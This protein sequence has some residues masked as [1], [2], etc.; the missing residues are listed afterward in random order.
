MLLLTN[1]TSSQKYLPFANMFADKC[2]YLLG[3]IE[4]SIKLSHKTYH[5]NL[6]SRPL[7]A[8]LMLATVWYLGKFQKLCTEMP[9]SP[10]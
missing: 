2:V 6:K 5:P 9:I 3:I 8:A 10:I 7:K 1:F 4:S